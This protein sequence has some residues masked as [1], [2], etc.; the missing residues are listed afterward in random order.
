MKFWNPETEELLS[1]SDLMDNWCG[2]VCKGK[3]CP[4]NDLASKSEMSG[5][6]CAEWISNHPHEAARLMG[7]EVVED[8]NKAYKAT[9]EYRLNVW[10][11]AT[12]IISG[13]PFRDSVQLKNDVQLALQK[14]LGTDVLITDGWMGLSGPVYQSP[15]LDNKD[16]AVEGMCCDCA[17]GGPC[18]S[19]EENEDCP[20]KKEDGTCW[21]PYTKEEANMDKPRICEVLGD[22]FEKI[23]EAVHNGWWEEKKR[24]GVNDHPDMRPY[25]ELPEN[26]KEYDRVT[27]RRVLDALGIKYPRKPRFTQQEVE[28]AKAVRHVFGRDGTIE[29]YSKAFTVPYSP[30]TF[31]HLYINEDLFPSIK[32][33]QSYTL[34][35]IIGHEKD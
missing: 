29:R 30:L 14:C 27:V 26:V 4:I 9:N 3:K 16:N 5:R 17:H 6:E 20:H 19:W 23:C 35:E 7:Y 18:C 28:D 13:V 12:D 31:D 15:N 22:E 21:V 8:E 34:Q 1:V 2:E 10:F 33:G 25:Q 32:P 24:Q 11:K